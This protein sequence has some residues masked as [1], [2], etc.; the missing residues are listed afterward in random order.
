MT[1]MNMLQTCRTLRL[2]PK[3]LRSKRGVSVLEVMV[4]MTI[5]SLSLLLL[6]NM[7]VVA[8]DANDWSNKATQATQAM[9]E[10][11]EEIRSTLDFD[12][13]SDSL[14]TVARS[15]TTTDLGNHLMQVDVTVSWMDVR[16]QSRSNTMSALVRVD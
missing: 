6:L 8:I 7:A 5:L 14:G 9:Q 3:K 12:N 16:S 10:K 11:L 15:W 13:G 1:K 4:A 2:I